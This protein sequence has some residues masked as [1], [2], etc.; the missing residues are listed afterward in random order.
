M[1]PGRQLIVEF[2]EDR[3]SPSSIIDL[4]TLGGYNSYGTALN[5]G[6]MVVGDSYTYLFY[7]QHAYCYESDSDTMMDLGT[8]GGDF[9]EALSLNDAG[10]IV[11]DATTTDGN[12]HAFL[13]DGS[14]LLDLGAPASKSTVAVGINAAGQIVGTENPQGD[15]VVFQAFIA[16]ATG[17]HPLDAPEGTSTTGSEVLASTVTEPWPLGITTVSTSRSKPPLATLPDTVP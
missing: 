6:G 4:G 11:G 3:C 15:D 13:Y 14:S 2:L 12:E 1:R 17:R 7:G 10:Q 9:S 16:D 8:L 5:N